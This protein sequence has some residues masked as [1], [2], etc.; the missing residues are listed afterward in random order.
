MNFTFGAADKCS[1]AV[2]KL[3]YDARTKN[4]K[5]SSESRDGNDYLFA[6]SSFFRP[7]TPCRPADLEFI[8]Q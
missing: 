5:A 7:S 8:E 4:K 6:P 3:S 1:V 2:E